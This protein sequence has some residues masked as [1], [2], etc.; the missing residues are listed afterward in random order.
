M[1]FVLVLVY[2]QD[3]E[4]KDELFSDADSLNGDLD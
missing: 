1:F 4:K 2:M 3:E